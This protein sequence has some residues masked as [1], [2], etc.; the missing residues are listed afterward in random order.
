MCVL[1]LVF[2]YHLPA[3][4][5]KSEEDMEASALQEGAVQ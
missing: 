4:L 2:M 3:A 1:I 5:C